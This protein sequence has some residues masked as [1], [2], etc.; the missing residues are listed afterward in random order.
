MR[1]FYFINRLAVLENVEYADQNRRAAETVAYSLLERL[2]KENSFYGKSS[3]PWQE[4]VI[5]LPETENICWL[6][7]HDRMLRNHVSKFKGQRALIQNTVV[8]LESP[9]NADVHDFSTKSQLNKVH[10]K[11]IDIEQAI[12]MQEVVSLRQELCDLKEKAKQSEKEKLFANEKLQS[13]QAAL[14]Q[15][16][17]QLNVSESNPRDRLSYSELEYNVSIERELV[18]ALSRECRLKT[19]LQGLAESLET[20]TKGGNANCSTKII[21]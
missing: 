21:S 12:L 6:E 1:N 17:S 11:H 16:Q 19:R 18:E 10:Q 8:D 4:G 20:A 7:E 13:L 2:K 15:L 14:N 5:I 3:A 9:F